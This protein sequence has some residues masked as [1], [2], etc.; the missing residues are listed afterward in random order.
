MLK[1]IYFFENKRV[2]KYFVRFFFI[3]SDIRVL[4]GSIYSLLLRAYSQKLFVRKWI[5][6]II[7]FVN[8]LLT[9]VKWAWRL[10]RSGTYLD[11]T[12]LCEHFLLDEVVI[13]LVYLDWP[14][15]PRSLIA[16]FAWRCIFVS[17][18]T[19]LALKDHYML[20]RLDWLVCRRHQCLRLLLCLLRLELLGKLLDGL[21][22]TNFNI[23]S[24][25]LLLKLTVLL[26]LLREDGHNL[27]L[28]YG[29]SRCEDHLLLRQTRNQMLWVVH[30]IHCPYACDLLRALG[31]LRDSL[32]LLLWF[33]ARSTVA[34]ILAVDWVLL[35][36]LM[37]DFFRVFLQ[38]MI[39]KRIHVLH[40]AHNCFEE[41]AAKDD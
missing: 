2:L 32:L 16:S 9:F 21:G 41:F 28:W 34:G 6:K 11:I 26:R 3:D 29:H 25:S 38:I 13:V 5:G 22:G 36:E 1:E 7:A 4:T 31:Y 8:R 40:L 10:V 33:A 30:L 17:L 39:I 24:G 18:I 19:T 20:R 14:L 27:F 23:W 37:T 35:D 15:A 12:T